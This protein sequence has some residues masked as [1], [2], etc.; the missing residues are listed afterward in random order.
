MI[1]IATIASGIG[2]GYLLHRMEVNHAPRQ[3]VLG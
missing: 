2:L 1:I 3:A